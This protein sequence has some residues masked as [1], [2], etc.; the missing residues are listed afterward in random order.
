MGLWLVSCGLAAYQPRG[1]RLASYG[2][3]ACQMWPCGLTAMDLWLGICGL[4]VCQL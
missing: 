1:L 4:A 3:V 2:L